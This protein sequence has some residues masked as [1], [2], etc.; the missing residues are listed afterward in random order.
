MPIATFD[1]IVEETAPTNVARLDDIVDVA[2]TSRPRVEDLLRPVTPVASHATTVRDPETIIS[3]PGE[4]ER[5]VAWSL[6]PKRDAA[7]ARRGQPPANVEP[8]AAVAAPIDPAAAAWKRATPGVQ[9]TQPAPT[10]PLTQLGERLI[11]DPVVGAKQAA[12][13]V[14]QLA[15]AAASSV[16]SPAVNRQSWDR[17]ADGSPKGDGFF[18][19]IQRPDGTVSS[20]ISV[21]VNIDGKEVEI[22]TLVPTLTPEERDWLINNDISDPS[23]IPPAII[24]KAVDHARPRLAAGQSPFAQPG[25]QQPASAADAWKR[26]TP[27]I[28]QTQATA[29]IAPETL[30]AGSDV[31]E[32]GFKILEPTLVAAGIV[33]PLGTAMSLAAGYG[34][35]KGTEM[36]ATMA[37]LSPEATRLLSNVMAG[38]AASVAPG[39]VRTGLKDAAAWGRGRTAAREARRSWPIDVKTGERVAPG[40]GAIIDTQPVRNSA[41]ALPA[42]PEPVPPAVVAEPFAGGSPPPGTARLSDIVAVEPA[43]IAADPAAAVVAAKAAV[44]ELVDQLPKGPD[45]APVEQPIESAPPLAPAAAPSDVAR[46]SAPLP[47]EPAALAPSGVAKLDDIVELA[48]APAPG[49][50]LETP[51]DATATT[52]AAPQ[53][54][55]GDA[56]ARAG[57]APEGQA[58][59]GSDRRIAEGPR[60]SKRQQHE[61]DLLTQVTQH[62]IDSGYAGDPELLYSELEKRA[63]AMREIKAEVD[64]AGGTGNALLRE[65]VKAGGL[66]IKAETGQQGELR[67]LKESG[68]GKRWGLFTGKRKGMTLDGA[69]EYLRQDPRF[70]HIE[71]INDLVDELTDLAHGETSLGDLTAGELGA[72]GEKW[73]EHVLGYTAA[74]E[75]LPSDADHFAGSAKDPETLATAGRGDGSDRAAPPSQI[76]RLDTGEVQTRLPEAG[77]VRETEVKTPAMEAPFSLT[78]EA[79]DA[80]S[81]QEGLGFDKPQTPAPKSGGGGSGV[82]SVGSVGPNAPGRPAPIP[83]PDDRRLFPT[84]PAGT[85]TSAHPVHFPELVDLARQLQHV[86]RVRKSLGQAFGMFRHERGIDILAGL[87]KAGQ[88]HQVAATLAHEIGH[89]VDYLPHRTL[90]RGNLLGRLFSLRDFLKHTFTADDGAIITNADIRAELKALSDKWR[91]WDEAKASA[92]FKK[93]RNSGKEQYADALSVLLNDPARLKAEAPTFYKEFFNA[94]DRKP[95]VRDAYFALQEVLSGTPEELVARRRAGVRRMFEE[96]DVKALELERRRLAELKQA[97]K[98]LWFRM[99]LQLVDRNYSVIDRVNNLP[100]D[101]HL[102]DDENPIYFLEERNYLGAQLKAFTEKYF[103]PVFSDVSKADIHWNAFGEALFYERIIAGDRSELANPRGLSP[104][105]AKPLYATLRKELGDDRVKVLD[106]AI[107]K[108]RAAV[109]RAAE[110]AYAAGLYTDELHAQMEENPAYVTFQVIDHLESGVTSKVYRQIGTLKDI[111][112]P[113]DA[114]IL[115]TLVTIRATEHQ[116]VKRSVLAF[117]AQHYPADIKPAN[118]VWSGK[119]HRPIESKDPKERLITYLEKGK[120]VGK[121]VDPYIADALEKATIGQNLAVV[122][123][124]R[125]INTGVFRPLFTTFNLGFQGF[126]A[127]RDFARFWKNVPTM[128]VGR[129][130]LR[131]Y[132][133]APIA[134]VRAFGLPAHPTKAQLDAYRTLLDAEEKKMLSVT[135]ND[136]INGRQV[137]DSQIEDILARTGVGGFKA[138]ERSKWV[139][140]LIKVLDVIRETGDFIETLPKAAALH[141]FTGKGSISTMPAST[142]SFIRRKVGSPDFLAGGTAKPITNEVFLFSNAITQAVRSDYEVATEPHTRSGF[143]WKTATANLLPK[144]LLAAG[145]AGLFGEALKRM[146]GRT[147]EYDRTNYIVI[148]LG[149]DDAGN[150]IY[151]RA[152]QDDSGRLIGGLFWKMLRLARGESDV[153]ETIAQVADYSAGQF[154]NVAPSLQTIG[155]ALQFASG[156]NPYDA[157][158][159]RNVFT[160]DEWKARDART[161]KKFIGWEFQQLGGGIVWKFYP[162]EPRPQQLTK[163]QRILELPVISNIAGRFVRITNYGETETFRATAADVARGEARTRMGERAAV[164][165]AIRTYQQLPST[166]RT[167]G[168]RWQL[169]RQVVEKVYADESAS[170]RGRRTNLVVKKLSLGLVRGEADPLAD[171]VLAA[172]SNDQKVAILREARKRMGETAFA[173]WLKDASQHDVISVNVRNALR[174]PTVEE[175]LR[176]PAAATKPTP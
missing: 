5:Q 78:G 142:R 80:G 135:F 109:K 160:D 84:A 111:V 147:T 138:P 79:H 26:A 169:A 166:E 34:A 175:G 91:P 82:A 139:K 123:I 161:V 46:P 71:D 152:P 95:D 130:V 64:A 115:K 116:K 140:P 30:N 27:A 40:E 89:L 54:Q 102:A 51:P 69:V 76:D 75:E 33:N 173:A 93:Y 134:R 4:T 42:G 146:L 44:T 176:K 47:Q 104:E 8:S 170:E 74:H 81:V 53:I 21:G 31:L 156:Q 45:A 92:S 12:G 86:P 52:A 83:K 153:V 11:T 112:N 165:D 65:L 137:E 118:T 61:T 125:T 73:W 120:L 63:A 59:A 67:W 22:P 66:A 141:E 57:A 70:Q 58:P 163:G 144:L 105:D 119:G 77:A 122:S 38:L 35:A 158:R 90:K 14:A 10:T 36:L 114:T 136:L 20:E 6:S 133:A 150:T 62:A 18:G 39:S 113:A 2:P 148:P 9:Q 154:P 151:L 88:E 96:G 7:A 127:L 1:D 43:P 97:G 50:T 121:Y 167:V 23:K 103:A 17:R 55:T 41:G 60:V 37:K 25:E 159:S 15:R 131:Y 68:L 99:K 72:V 126:N 168:R 94:L 3:K 172:G 56:A 29:P 100:A 107:V 19:V 171:S 87:F 28:Q 129:A 149:E 16:T 143:W 106:P 48:P 13:G 132:Q 98:D 32:G 49:V 124:L 174:R 108:F 110:D 117:L 162:G 164:N 128:S 85:A 101:V 155:A 145:L 157:F 24:Q